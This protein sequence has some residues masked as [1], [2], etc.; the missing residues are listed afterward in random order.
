MT[1]KQKRIQRK[2]RIDWWMKHAHGL[3]SKK[4]MREYLAYYW[5]PGSGPRR[6]REWS[7]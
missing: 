1:R 3:E 7:V 6:Y 4:V 5:G 2:R